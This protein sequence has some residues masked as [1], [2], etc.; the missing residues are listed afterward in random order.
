MQHGT[1]KTKGR[2]SW[3][4][5]GNAYLMAPSA[6]GSGRIWSSFTTMLR[7]GSDV[8]PT[9]RMWVTKALWRGQDFQRGV[10]IQSVQEIFGFLSAYF[11][12]CKL[13]SMFFHMST[14]WWLENTTLS[15]SFCFGSFSK[16]WKE[17][18]QKAATKCHSDCWNLLS[19]RLSSMARPLCIARRQGLFGAFQD[20][21]NKVIGRRLRVEGES[22]KRTWRLNTIFSQFLSG[23]GIEF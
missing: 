17:S 18:R 23:T 20:A 4:A 12:N 21:A 22:L 14:N 7:C 19:R 10:F 15:W 2:P 1:F 13:R 9:T 5:A 11:A 8:I 16:K 3:S 6:N